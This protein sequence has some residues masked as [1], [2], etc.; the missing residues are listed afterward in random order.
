MDDLIINSGFASPYFISVNGMCG[1]ENCAV[2]VMGDVEQPHELTDLIEQFKVPTVK[3]CDLYVQLKSKTSVLLFVRSIA[4]PALARLVSER[5]LGRLNIC[6]IELPGN[7][8]LQLIKAE[9]IAAFC[10]GYKIKAVI[11]KDKCV[12]TNEDKISPPK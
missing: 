1:L 11:D 6:V 2:I 7:R 5:L 12:L 4:G 8:E 10:F 9:E 3:V